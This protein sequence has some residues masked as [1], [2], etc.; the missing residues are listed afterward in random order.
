ME[1]IV[2]TKEELEKILERVSLK[3]RKETQEDFFVH[4]KELGLSD[5]PKQEEW[6]DAKDAMRLLNVKKSKLQSLRDNGEILFSQHGR[7]IHYSRKS[8]NDFL[9]RHTKNTF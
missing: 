1:V 9:N 3:V 5:A 7:T 8:I 4:I 6:I 2:L